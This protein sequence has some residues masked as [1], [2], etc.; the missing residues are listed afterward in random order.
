MGPLEG[1]ESSMY[2]EIEIKCK[3]RRKRRRNKKQDTVEVNSKALRDVCLIPHLNSKVSE[4]SWSSFCDL[5]WRN[6]EVACLQTFLHMSENV[7]SVRTRARIDKHAHLCMF[8]KEITRTAGPFLV[9][10]GR[11]CRELVGSIWSISLFLAPQVMQSALPG[12]YTTTPWGVGGVVLT[13]FSFFSSFIAEIMVSDTEKNKPNIFCVMMLRLCRWTTV[14]LR[15]RC[16]CPWARASPCRGRWKS[17]SWRPVPPGRTSRAAAETAA[18]FASRWPSETVEV[19]T[20]TCSSPRRDAWD[21]AH[22]V[23][24]SFYNAKYSPYVMFF[25]YL[26]WASF[27][28]VRETQAEDRMF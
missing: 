17:G 2:R 23:G 28:C 12:W 16:G 9:C 11:T 8:M 4:T 14:G 25:F 22:K 1:S 19:S 3:G 24:H 7:K 15:L 10:W 27:V 13:R 5:M 26:G 6:S 18:C 21:T 20:F